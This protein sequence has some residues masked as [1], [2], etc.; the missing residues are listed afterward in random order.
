M[1]AELAL[2]AIKKSGI[3]EK[4]FNSIVS[5]EASNCRLAREII[6]DEMESGHLIEFRCM[7]HFFN[8]IGGS[9][10][11]SSQ[12]RTSFDKLTTLISAVTNR[13]MLAS[14]LREL[15]AKRLV[16]ATPTRWYTTCASINAALKI[17]N[18]PDLVPKTEEF[19]F[20]KW[21]S[22]LSDR[23]FWND[24]RDSK[25]YFDRLS[26]MI[27]LAEASNSRLSNAFKSCLE[28]GFLVMKKLDENARFRESAIEAFISQ[29]MRLD[30]DLMFA[31][32]ILDPNHRMKYLTQ[33]SLK[34]GKE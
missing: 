15:G 5:D 11:K 29:F 27:G 23:L 16:H 13:K 7:A 32:Y 31:A 9:I 21:G 33:K 4:K 6:V 2:A 24:L 25:V 26:S 28:F 17:K 20:S 10:S 14:K 8:L 34:R 1:I 18:I 19:G 12:L 22:I 3:P 30:L